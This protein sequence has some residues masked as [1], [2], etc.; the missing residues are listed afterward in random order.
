VKLPLLMKQSG[1]WLFSFIVWWGVLWYLSS[2]PIEAPEVEIPHWDKIAHCGYF[3]GGA[4]FLS[5]GLFLRKFRG[6]RLSWG[7]LGFV[8]LVVLFFTGSLDEW[9]QS[10]HPERMG[11]DAGDLTADV[12]GSLFGIFVFRRLH[13]LLLK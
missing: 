3:F 13:G 12:V 7:T 1:F 2:G 4:G 10:W 9:H 11:N 6:K 5:A 8:V